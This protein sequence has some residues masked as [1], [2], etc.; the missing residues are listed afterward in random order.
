[1][2]ALVYHG[3]HHIALE[4]V[5]KPTLLKPTDVIVKVTKTTICGTDLGIYKGKNLYMR[6][7]IVLGHEGVGIVDEVGASVTQFQ[8][9]DKVI[10]SCITSCGS[11]DYCK[12]QLYA[13][14]RDGGWILGHMIDG[15]QAEYVR[16]P[17]ADNSLFKI[18]D[19]LDDEV[20]VMLSDILPTGHEVGVKSGDVKPGDTVAIVGAGPVGLA[21]LLTAQFYSPSVLIVIDFD[22][23]RLALAKEL[24]ATHMLQPSDD[25]HEKIAEIV[26][27]D[28]V[29]V[30]IEAVGMP[31]T[32]EV[33]EKIVK[34][35]GHIA[36][37]G[38]HGKPVTFQLQDLWIKNLTITTGLVSTNTTPMLLKSVATN[39]LPVK[40]LI[41]HHFK[42]NEMERAYDVF[43]N[44]SKEN[45]LKV[46][47]DVD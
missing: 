9:G 29:D 4:D 45:A 8:K 46:I 31:A 10:I 14:C 40:K 23:N 33:C 36:V 41:T 25:I 15:T 34:P 19:E 20:A 18:P 39:K 16:I 17:N 7:G 2:K 37:V 13:H 42:L 22:E 21:A 6:D 26:G 3:E 30:A 35:G 1:M 28:G 43:L 32:W 11:C 44:A 5:A 27:T 24:G 38:V 47:I 12:R